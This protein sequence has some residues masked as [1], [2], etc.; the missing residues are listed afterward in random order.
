MAFYPVFVFALIHFFRDA[1][2]KTWKG[3]LLY[4]HVLFALILFVHP[5]WTPRLLWV[6]LSLLLVEASSGIA[7][8]GKFPRAVVLASCLIFAL[9]AISMERKT[10]G[11]FKETALAVKGS[12][13]SGRVVSDEQAKTEFYLGRGITVYERD[14][15]RPEDILILH[16]YNTDLAE[17]KIFLD[18]TYV[19]RPLFSAES[20]LVPL[21]AGTALADI[22][23]TNSPLALIQRFQVQKFQSVVLRIERKRRGAGATL[24]PG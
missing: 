5:A 19:Y 14:N 3:L 13:P 21:L 10:F 2:D 22:D 1:E 4:V 24:P 6:P 12:F 18:Q 8:I 7:R 11:D 20:S 15:L 9:V 16:S 23:H 17:E